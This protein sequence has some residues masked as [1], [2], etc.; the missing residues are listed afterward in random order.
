LK[1]GTLHLAERHPAP[2]NRQ[3]LAIGIGSIAAIAANVVYYLLASELL[4]IPMVA[5][6]EDPL[7]KLSPLPVTD[8]IIFSLVFSIGASIIFLVTANFSPR[9]AQVY[10]GLCV[11]VLIL[12]LFM[13]LMIP[14]PPVPMATKFV[15]ASM[16]VLG[17]AVL[18][19][20]LIALGLP[21]K[22]ERSAILSEGRIM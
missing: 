22:K 4:D 16:H 10:V 3:L 6:S 21:P 5:P 12:S 13:P 19:P 7:E 14:T 20:I 15:L 8:V 17:A 11:V 2:I 1:S 9:P 18:V